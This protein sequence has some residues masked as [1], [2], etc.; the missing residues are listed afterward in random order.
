MTEQSAKG[1]VAFVL[2]CELFNNFCAALGICAI[3]FGHD[4]DGPTVNAASG[5]DHLRGGLGGAV[6][7]ATIGSTDTGAVNLETNSNGFGTC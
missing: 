6:I 3:I 4:F 7:P 1:D 2:G 5:I